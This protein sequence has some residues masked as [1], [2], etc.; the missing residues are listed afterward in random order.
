MKTKKVFLRLFFCIANVNVAVFGSREM[1][2][3]HEKNAIFNALYHLV[4]APETEENLILLSDFF[5]KNQNFVSQQFAYATVYTKG[6]TL[7]HFFANQRKL[8]SL[9]LLA[10]HGETAAQP[11]IH[12][13]ANYA[14]CK[15]STAFLNLCFQLKSIEK[16]HHAQFLNLLT[17]FAQRTPQVVTMS[18]IDGMTP[19]M[20]IAC[21][22]SQATTP[23]L[24]IL[25]E[26]NQNA[27]IGTT[28]N[29]EQAY[30]FHPLSVAHHLIRS[31]QNE[32]TTPALQW[33]LSHIQRK[34]HPE[35]FELHRQYLSKYAQ[36]LK[37]QKACSILENISP[38]SQFTAQQQC[39]CC[40]Q[41][42]L[43]CTTPN[44]K[45]EHTK[46]WY[47]FYTQNPDH[48]NAEKWLVKHDQ[49]VNGL[50]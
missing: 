23:A 41:G 12:A 37:R 21:S 15:K 29:F 40:L 34:L 30:N 42:C 14:K 39:S 36:R 2:I 47:D 16:E 17:I 48:L 44:M 31:E 26:H 33:I 18:R 35:M 20:A 11:I 3:H 9:C 46:F 1:P 49:L 50:W 19:A 28:I 8:G 24:Q 13:N 45:S 10:H 7:A 38:L 43:C 22:N 6:Q 4:C 5:K 27:F 25:L 32:I